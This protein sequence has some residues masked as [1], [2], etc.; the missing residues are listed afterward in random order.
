MRV[1]VHSCLEMSQRWVCIIWT[2]CEGSMTTANI[3]VAGLQTAINLEDA[4]SPSL[5]IKMCCEMSH[6]RRD[7]HS[8][9]WHFQC[10]WW[11]WRN[12]PFILD[13]RWSLWLTGFL[14]L[15]GCVLFWL[16]WM[17]WPTDLCDS[18]SSQGMFLQKTLGLF[19]PS[20]T[21]PHLKNRKQML[22]FH[23]IATAKNTL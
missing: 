11:W 13:I 21:N 15:L 3:R 10:N 7:T 20:Y 23:I 19:F 22:A 9:D 16:H 8:W 1:M 18:C 2:S 4:G 17:V 14:L 12:S 6:A 5:Q